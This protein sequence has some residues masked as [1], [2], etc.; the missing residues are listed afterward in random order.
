MVV[1]LDKFEYQAEA[2]LQQLAEKATRESWS[3]KN[4]RW[5]QGVKSAFRQ[6]ASESGFKWYATT[7]ERSDNTEWLLDGVAYEPQADGGFRLPFVMES[8]WESRLRREDGP[9]QGVTRDFLKLVVTR[10]DHRV[11]V[12]YASS[13]NK[14]EEGIDLLIGLATGFRGSASGDRY[15]FACWCQ[16]SRRFVFRS[17]VAER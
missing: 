3:D 9:D 4:P 12:F 2:A 7:S 8:E 11:M 15:L 5:T 1:E 13:Q 17:F 16:N 10:A 14:A 6:I